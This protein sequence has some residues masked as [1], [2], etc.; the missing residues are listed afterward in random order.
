MQIMTYPSRAR[1]ALAAAIFFAAASFAFSQ[2]APVNPTA[3][4]ATAEPK[5]KSTVQLEKF[6]VTDSKVDGLN[7]KT[8]FRTD[9]KA[10]LPYNVI[11]SLEIERMGATNIQEI[12]RSLPQITN[13]GF[14]T[15][16]NASMVNVT[17]GDT[18][19]N[20][21]AGLRGFANSQTVVLV[22]GRRINGV[23]GRLRPVDIARDLH[24]TASTGSCTKWSRTAE[25]KASPAK[26][27]RTASVTMV[28]KSASVSPCV[29]IPPPAG[30]SHLATKPP[31]SAQGVTVRTNSMTAPYRR[32]LVGQTKAP[33]AFSA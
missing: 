19:S 16:A 25:G 2:V 9:E 21:S 30:S 6:Q 26:Y 13:Y 7:N 1:P 32:H 3:T 12:F 27:P 11:S 29:Q 20:D 10:P 4:P 31:V 24:A 33:S 22:N 5:D 14:S 28:C 17:G 15:Q 8:I 23:L 18:L